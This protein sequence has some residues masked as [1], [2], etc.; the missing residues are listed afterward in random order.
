MCTLPNT[1]YNAQFVRAVLKMIENFAN[2]QA[3]CILPKLL[4]FYA[5]IRHTWAMCKCPVFHTARNILAN[6]FSVAQINTRKILR[7]IV[8]TE[9][10]YKYKIEKQ[11]KADTGNTK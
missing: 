11:T 6:H 7:D 3:F 10:Q 8:D 5:L 1:L 4:T 9:H 2:F